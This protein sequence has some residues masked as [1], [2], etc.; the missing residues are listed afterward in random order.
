MIETTQAEEQAHIDRELAAEQARRAAEERE[1]RWHELMDEARDA[2]KEA[3][4]VEDLTERFARW[5]DAE[6]LRTF[7]AAV[8][9]RHGQDPRARGWLT[10]A[11][12]HLARLDP[13]SS[14]PSMPTV[15]DPSPEQLR[16]FMPQVGARTPL[17]SDSRSQAPTAP[18]RREAPAG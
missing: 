18:G 13:L 6:A 14:T 16:P 4:R 8:E 15:P 7:L 11:G 1:A 12:D 17:G 3:R 2:F 10:W 9:E 5:R